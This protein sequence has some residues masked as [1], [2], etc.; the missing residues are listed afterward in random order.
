MLPNAIEWIFKYATQLH[1]VIS[2]ALRTEMV[3]GKI[4][5]FSLYASTPKVHG[6]GVAGH[7]VSLVAELFAVFVLYSWRSAAKGSIRAARQAGTVH[8]RTATT[9]NMI[10]TAM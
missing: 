3:A 10:G 6:H 4:E 5:E 9:T 8:A 2:V 1:I 7:R